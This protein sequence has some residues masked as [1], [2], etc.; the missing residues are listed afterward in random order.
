MMI[1][2]PISW[3]QKSVLVLSSHY[4]ATQFFTYLKEYARD[5]IMI[6]FVRW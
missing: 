1:Q 5:H 2:A 4:R 6:V 3:K